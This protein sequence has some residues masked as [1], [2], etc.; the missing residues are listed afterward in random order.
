MGLG[1]LR[2]ARLEHWRLYSGHYVVR[3]VNVHLFGCVDESRRE[4]GLLGSPGQVLRVKWDAVPTHARTRIK[5][6]VAERFGS[7][8]VDHFPDVDVE[9]VG[10]LSHLVDQPDIDRSVGVLQELGHLGRPCRRNQ[11][12]RGDDTS[13]GGGGHLSGAGRDPA[14][15][16]RNVAR[17]EFVA[18]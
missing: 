1:F 15:H 13:V 4:V 12:H 2:T 3:H 8:G 10:K 6:L 11:M 9:V 16:L 18:W 5:G 17:L 7:G 14:D